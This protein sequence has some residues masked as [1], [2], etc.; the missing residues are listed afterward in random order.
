MGQLHNIRILQQHITVGAHPSMVF[1]SQ[2]LYLNI[3]T[4]H[5]YF[6]DAVPS[7]HQAVWID[8]PSQCICSTDHKP[9]VCTP[10]RWQ[11]C[12]DPW[13]I[14]KYNQILWEQLQKTRLAT[15]RGKKQIIASPTT[16][17]QGN[18]PGGNRIQVSCGK[19]LQEDK[20]SAMPWCPQVS[21][22]INHILYWKEWMCDWQLSFS[23]MSKERRNQRSHQQLPSQPINNKGKHT[24]SLQAVP[25][26][27]D[28]WGMQGH[29]DCRN[30]PSPSNSKRNSTQIFVETI[31]ANQTH[32]KNSLISP[33]SSTTIYLG[34]STTSSY[35]H[36]QWWTMT[37]VQNV[38][39]AGKG[40]LRGGRPEVLPGQRHSLLQEP[41]LKH[42][43]EIGTNN[44]A[45]KQVIV[46]KLQPDPRTNKFVQKLLQHMQ[47][48]P[49]VHDWMPWLL[50]KYSTGWQKS[51]ETTESSP[52]GIYFGH[53]IAGTFNPNIQLFNAT[54][55][56]LPMKT[57]YSPQQWRQGVNIM[58]EKT[59][60]NFNVE[61]LRIILLFEV[62]FNANNKWMGRAVMLMAETLNLLAD[63]QYSSCKHK[64]AVLQCFNKALF[65]NLM[66]QW[67]QPVALCSNDAKSCYNQITLLAAALSLCRLGTLIPA[68]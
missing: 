34:S 6:G 26:I 7:N 21:Q 59:P 27:K 50:Q 29:M 53:Y 60:G 22:M 64:A 28:R 36:C 66:W 37:R 58:L 12:K 11:Q 45:F 10:A 63:E 47:H 42:F 9:I 30:Y 51:W 39:H 2:S 38:A 33:S 23:P 61:K 16:Q 48:P 35:R 31:P 32:P 24:T 14:N 68:V 57:G 65:Y 4:Q 15:E 55:T 5:T 43:G 54:M 18:W 49:Q 46:G 3:A 20:A 8:I 40:M 44:L 56:D 25:F 17:I 1:L 67:K 19:N 41:I 62:D 52:S 13:V